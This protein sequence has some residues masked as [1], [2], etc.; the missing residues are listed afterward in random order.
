MLTPGHRDDLRRSGVT[1]ETMARAGL[2]SATGA[3]V[4]EV[5][6]YNASPG[7]VFP[8]PS[9]NGG[10][11]TYARVKLDRA[12]ADGK[13]YRAPKGHGNRL[14]IPPTLDPAVLEDAATPVWLTE[15][16]KKSLAAVQAGLECVA[17]PGVW[18]WRTR[19]AA[20]QSQ[21]IADL[22]AVAWR[23][24]TVYLVFDS[25]LGTNPQVRLAEFRLA[26]E[27]R[28]RGATVQAIRLPS[29]P[30][31]EK[32]GLDDYLLTHSIEALCMLD[33]LDVLDLAPPPP[34]RDDAMF[35]GCETALDPGPITGTSAE[36][37]RQE[38]GSAEGAPA[39]TA[40]RRSSARTGWPRWPRA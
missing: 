1:D 30:S 10:P 39:R 29:G 35:D 24:R 16:E 37:D 28:A 38:G 36:N 27:L 18:S 13:R 25:D 33:P 9:L 17:L 8:Y 19:D 7:L 22:D 40:R 32:V 14:Y 15:G 20:G 21:P 34:V 5:R 23:G 11:S 6:G 3:G 31:G 26:R 2:Y 12:G 4:R